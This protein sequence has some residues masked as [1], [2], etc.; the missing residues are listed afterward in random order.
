MTF[1][2]EDY[3]M[4]VTIVVS[5]LM[6]WVTAGPA[7][8]LPLFPSRMFFFFITMSL[9]GASLFHFI[10]AMDPTDMSGKVYSQWVN[11]IARTGMAITGGIM[12]WRWQGRPVTKQKSSASSSSASAMPSSL[13]AMS[14]QER[15]I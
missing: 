9:I 4:G 10:R 2:I 11:A 6:L 12:I 14:L 13:P 1:T 7:S 8:Q 3:L 5:V 15:H